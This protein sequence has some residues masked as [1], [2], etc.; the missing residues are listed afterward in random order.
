MREKERER[1]RER[2]RKRERERRRYLRINSYLSKVTDLG[3]TQK[4]MIDQSQASI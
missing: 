4:Q 2:E 3:L 1:E